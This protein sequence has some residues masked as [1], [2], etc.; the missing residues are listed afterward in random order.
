MR[1][2]LVAT[3]GLILLALAWP[4]AALAVDP[5]DDIE[6]ELIDEFAFLED[7]GMVE[8]SSRHRQDIGMSPSAVTVLTREDVEASGAT[9]IPDLLRLVPGM[10]VVTISPTFYSVSSRLRWSNANNHYQALIDGRDAI[11]ELMGI[12]P[13]ALE[14][15]FLDDVERIEILRGPASSMYGASALAGVV[16][17][18][19]RV[20]PEKTS[21]SARLVAG[22]VGLTELGGRVSTRV[23]SWGF[24]LSGGIDFTGSFSDHRLRGRDMWRLRAVSEYVWSSERRL[25]MDVSLVS[26]MGN[27]STAV[28]NID[29]DAQ[30]RVVRLSYESPKISGRLYWSNTPFDLSL[31]APLEFGGIHLADFAPLSAQP[32]IVDG[33]IQW[34]LPE[35]WKPLLLIVG[36]GGRFSWL[37]A[38]DLLDGETFA[39]ISSPDYHKPGVDHWEMR[40]AAFAHAEY[41]PEEWVT[42]SASARFDYNT[43]TGFFVSPRAVVVFRPAKNH[44]LRMGVSRSF[45]KPAFVETRF[46]PMVSFPTD[47]PLTGTAQDGFLEFMSRQISNSN[48]ENEELLSYETGYL[49]RF[50]DGE[51]SI[52]V[53][54]YYNQFRNIVEMQADV[55]PGEQGLPDLDETSIQPKNDSRGIDLHGG[56]VVLRY[57]PSRQVSLMASWAFREELSRQTAA[58]ATTVPKNMFT[59]GG[60]FRMESGCVGSLYLFS[61]S[62]IDQTVENPK[63]LFEPGLRMH[64]PTALLLMGKV[65]W[66]WKVGAH[67][68]LETGA[69]LFL[70]ISPDGD[71]LFRYYEAAGGVSTSGKYYGGE[72]LSRMVTLYLQGTY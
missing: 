21:T 25:R 52:A 62:A 15:V 46:H 29:I 30:T 10:S 4:R 17:I 37:T 59:I 41:K 20:V 67:L 66:R 24:A 5:Y 65:G 49:G 16:S 40:G 11:N 32:H 23:G 45:R 55:V 22:E 47:S 50:L 44:F 39:D 68:D 72:Q 51:L 54:L 35:L 1:V 69:K 57:E 36:A 27:F 64:L 19:T 28:G 3:S 60:R 26:G 18:T 2:S 7:A 58:V 6:A 34:T 63:G 53:D 61:R 38:D 42:V 48:L 43:E 13:W 70:P 71:H 8:L 14:A 9:T 12:V 33:E 56:E 31:T